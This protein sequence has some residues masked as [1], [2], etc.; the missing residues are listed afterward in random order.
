MKTVRDVIIGAFISLFIGQS[1]GG[2]IDNKLDTKLEMK[3]DSR[4][5]VHEDFNGEI[6]WEIR[7]EMHSF[8]EQYFGLPST[9]VHG[10]VSDRGKGLLGTLSPGFP[11]KDNLVMSPVIDLGHTGTYFLASLG[12][13]LGKGFQLT[14]PRFDGTDFRFVSL[15]NQLRFPEIYGS[16]IF[17]HNLKPYIASVELDNKLKSLTSDKF[18]D[19]PEKLE[20]TEVEV[21]LVTSVLS[22]HALSGSQGHNTMRLAARIG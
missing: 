3:L 1:V 10:G 11:P 21:E 19:C 2:K 9:T 5:K 16:S 22:L 18:Q 12:D 15:L 7:A 13:L 20:V 4:F 8:F 14:W 17:V 6:R